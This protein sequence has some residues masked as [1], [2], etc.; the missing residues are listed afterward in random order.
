MNSE[1][2]F[3]DSVNKISKGEFRNNEVSDYFNSAIALMVNAS[4]ANKIK[5]TFTPF[6]YQPSA[7]LGCYL[8]SEKTKSEYHLMYDFIT[9]EIFF[10]S[11]L[12][13]WEN[14][15]NINDSFWSEFL[16][17]S[18]K[19]NFRFEP[20]EGIAYDKTITPEFNSNFKSILFNIMAVYVTSMLRSKKDRGNIGFGQ[21]TITWAPQKTT[22]EILQELSFAFKYFY[23]L[24]YLLWK[25]EDVRRQN[26]INKKG[27]RT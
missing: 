23:Q 10:Y 3:F 6:Y 27:K 19:I 2:I 11:S 5:D 7:T 22:D 20:F 16:A 9:N 13:N 15:K 25:T 14:I 8:K 26:R 1:E 4:K 12:K 17:A 18:Q 21:L 24:N